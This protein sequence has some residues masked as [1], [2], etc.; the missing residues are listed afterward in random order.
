MK[1]ENKNHIEI[2]HELEKKIVDLKKNSKHTEER[3][4]EA[5]DYNGTDE[6][7]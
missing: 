7:L 2:N 5:S 4:L 3:K 1:F 6:I